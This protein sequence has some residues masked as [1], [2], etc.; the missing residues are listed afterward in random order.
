[1]EGVEYELIPIEGI[2]KAFK[3]RPS[4]GVVKLP[5]L[6]GAE[7]LYQMSK[8]LPDSKSKL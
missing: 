5:R 6:K 1:M 4:G 3:G 8:T 2:L 7:E